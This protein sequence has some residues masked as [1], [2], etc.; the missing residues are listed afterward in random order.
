MG[1][2]E[3]VKEIVLVPPREMVF[4]ILMNVLFN[5]RIGFCMIAFD[6]TLAI[7]LET[8][9]RRKGRRIRL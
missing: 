4:D 1:V 2:I 9:E 6:S 5:S 8:R 3:R 7:S